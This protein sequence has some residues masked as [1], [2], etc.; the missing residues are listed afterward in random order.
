MRHIVIV[1]DDPV[2]ALLFRKVLE[3]RGGFR[4]TVTE[5]PEE[6]LAIAR[7]RDL[8]MVVLDVSL[9][10]SRYQGLPVNGVDLCRLLKA[11]EATSWVPVLLATAHAMRGDSER[12]IAES[13]ADGYVAKPITD[14]DAFVQHVQSL[15]REAA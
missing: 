7:S 11:D 4:V 10:N 15:A 6:L 12:L 5:D 13:G 2:N 9:A 3:K 1:E 14:H 8:V